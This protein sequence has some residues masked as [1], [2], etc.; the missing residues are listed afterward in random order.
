MAHQKTKRSTAKQTERIAPEQLR[1]AREWLEQEISAGHAEQLVPQL[2]EPEP[3]RPLPVLIE[4][5]STMAS[6]EAAMLLGQIAAKTDAKDLH[7]AIRRALYRLKTS[8]VETAS[9]PP[10]EPRKSVLEVPKL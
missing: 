5:L 7:K 1:A 8:G 2:I 3:S 6:T 9:L 10:Q 4:A